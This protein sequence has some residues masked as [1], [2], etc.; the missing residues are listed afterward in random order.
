[1]FAVGLASIISAP[2]FIPSSLEFCTF[3]SPFSPNPQRVEGV[4]AC[5]HPGRG[6]RKFFPAKWH[7]VT[8]GEYPQK[9]PMSC[10][11]TTSGRGQSVPSVYVR[12][13]HAKVRPDRR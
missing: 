12:T 4:F 8:F 7:D 9:K 10:V 5:V 3:T 11:R 1:M 13:A 2:V 6:R